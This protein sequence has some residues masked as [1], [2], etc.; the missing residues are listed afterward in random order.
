MTKY[1]L[2]ITKSFKNF[3]TFRYIGLKFDQINKLLQNLITYNDHKIKQVWENFTIHSH[4]CR[5]SETSN[6]KRLIWIIM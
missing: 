3:F 2:L 4:R 5:F 1:K 6:N